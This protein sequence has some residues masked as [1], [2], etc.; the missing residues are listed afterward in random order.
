MD[1]SGST[2]DESFETLVRTAPPRMISHCCKREIRYTPAPLPITHIQPVRMEISAHAD[3]SRV[4]QTFTTSRVTPGEKET[5]DIDEI[6]VKIHVIQLD[7]RKE[8]RELLEGNLKC[9]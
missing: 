1:H 9:R 5:V 4:H 7:E 3:R 2:N 6:F 8:G